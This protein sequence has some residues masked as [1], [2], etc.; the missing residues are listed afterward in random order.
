MDSDTAML[1]PKGLDV[2]DD[3]AVLT[4]LALTSASPQNHTLLG[5]TSTFGNA[6]TESTYADATA[7]LAAAGVSPGI[8][9]HKGVGAIHL[10]LKESSDATRYIVETVLA[11]EGN[12]TIICTGALTNV[13]S[14]FAQEP[15]IMK[16][17]A[18]V[19]IGDG[20]INSTNTPLF[21]VITNG[22]LFFDL[23][24]TRALFAS[25]VPKVVIPFQ[26]MIQA[27]FNATH[28]AYIANTTECQGSVVHKSLDRLRAWQIRS[29]RVTAERYGRFPGYKPGGFL[30]WDTFAV[31]HT[32]DPELFSSP[33]RYSFREEGV[34]RLH[35][36]LEE[37]PAGDIEASDTLLDEGEFMARLLHRL[38]SVHGE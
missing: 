30:P 16:K 28:I 7:L 13:A 5:V 17:V 19:I 20:W 2:D 1:D 26:L 33:K 23:H 15:Q 6:M 35:L 12:V 9:A 36:Y 14:A 37:D 38:C 29:E 8:A 32:F 34:A 21:D 31:S 24:A 25:P 18:K 27:S 3:L 22:N 10:G 4:A 11:H